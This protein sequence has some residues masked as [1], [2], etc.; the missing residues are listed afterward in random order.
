MDRSSLLSFVRIVACAVAVFA[1]ACD[2]EDRAEQES[3]ASA[4]DSGTDAAG[5]QADSSVSERAVPHDGGAASA[6]AGPHNEFSIGLSTTACKGRCPIFDLKLN[7]S[8]DVELNG[9]GNTRQQGWVG[10]MVST[11]TAAELLGAIIAANYWELADRYIAEADGCTEL[12]PEQSTYTWSLR[13]DGPTKIV[14]DY[15]GCKGVPE[16]EALRAIPALL[17]DKLELERWVQ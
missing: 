17:I 1:G 3:R 7:Q 12:E 10:K 5:P 15:Q 13:T 9:R 4:A 16:V 2:D 6:D 11:E 8:G 14:I